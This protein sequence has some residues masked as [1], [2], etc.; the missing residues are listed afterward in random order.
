MS[1]LEE[2]AAKPR[3]DESDAAVLLA[4]WR[5]SG[6][7]AAPFARSLGVG[8][9]RFRRWVS[10]DRCG[11]ERPALQFVEVRPTPGPATAPALELVLAGRVLRIPVGFDADT[12]RRAVL[13]LEAAPC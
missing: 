12:L 4:A 9:E 13:A 2:I 7:K 8:E 11:G 1:K 3:W 5:R 10:G 6:L